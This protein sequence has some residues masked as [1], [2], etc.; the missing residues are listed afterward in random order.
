[1]AGVKATGNIDEATLKKIAAP[2]C[3]MPDLVPETVT[4]PPGVSHDAPDKP[5]SYYVPGKISIR[6]ANG[7]HLIVAFQNTAHDV[8]AMFI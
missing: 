3:G 1:M 6:Y 4:I 5:E 2:R 8:Q 7:A